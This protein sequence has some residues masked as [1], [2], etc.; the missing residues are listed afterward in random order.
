MIVSVPAIA[1]A[2]VPFEIGKPKLNKKKGTATLAVEVPE[3]G[4]VSVTTAKNL[5]ATEIFFDAAGR[6]RLP[7]RPRQGKPIQVLKNTGKLKAKLAV[8]F[9]PQ[10]PPTPSGGPSSKVLTITLRLDR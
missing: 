4:K 10:G 6:G 1:A 8:T 9:A 5:S 3:K 2:P 7:I